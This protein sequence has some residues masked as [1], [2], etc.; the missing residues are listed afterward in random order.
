[1]VHEPMRYN[2]NSLCKKTFCK[3]LYCSKKLL[4]HFEYFER[5][6]QVVNYISFCKMNQSQPLC[7]QIKNLFNL[8]RTVSG[9]VG[10]RVL[11]CNKLGVELEL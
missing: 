2:S 5:K 7:K 11:G 10:Q 3:F 6:D 9:L 4:K 8:Y 1:M